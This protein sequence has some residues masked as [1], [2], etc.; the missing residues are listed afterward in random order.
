MDP[1]W[2]ILAF[3]DSA[4]VSFT[5]FNLVPLQQRNTVW[6]MFAPPP[7][8]LRPFVD[9]WEDHAK[10]ALAQFR[11][12]SAMFTRDQTLTALV[13]S[14]K[15]ISPEFNLW[16]PDGEVRGK[17]EGEK[18]ILHPTP[19]RL[20]LEQTTTLTESPRLRF[21]VYIPRDAET[22]AKISDL[23]GKTKRRASGL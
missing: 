13:A 20:R 8:G 2:N 21:V 6:L 22:N 23:L 4:K 9:Q 3:N 11:S 14:L 17:R 12:D 16:W 5:D 1:Y 10:R 18:D 7:W 15:E 19:W